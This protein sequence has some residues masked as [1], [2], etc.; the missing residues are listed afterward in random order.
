MAAMRITLSRSIV[1]AM[2]FAIGVAKA[3]D[4]EVTLFN[5][6]GKAIAYIAVSDDMTIYMWNGKPVAYMEPDKGATGFHVYGFN[7]KHLGWF[8]KGLIRD[9]EGDAACA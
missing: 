2:V 1:F 8:V 6:K 7:G 3:S 9:H 5:S 4:E